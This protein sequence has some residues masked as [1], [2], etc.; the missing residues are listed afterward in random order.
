MVLLLSFPQVSSKSYFIALYHLYLACY[1]HDAPSALQ[2]M[3]DQWQQDDPNIVFAREVIRCILIRRNPFR[4][5]QLYREC[6]EPAFQKLMDFAVDRVRSRAV[7]VMAKAYYDIPV[8]WAGHWLGLE[9]EEDG[10]LRQ[11]EKILPGCVASVT[12]DHRI[13]FMRKK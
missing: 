12:E 10:V 2:E 9:K 4:F 3:A 1:L 7:N 13:Q 5:F 8:A 11:F 6:P